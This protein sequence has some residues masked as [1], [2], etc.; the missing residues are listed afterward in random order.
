MAGIVLIKGSEDADSGKYQKHV[1]TGKTRTEQT[2]RLPSAS[3]GERL[4][5]D[6]THWHLILNFYLL[7][8]RGN[9]FLLFKPH[10][11]WSN[12]EGQLL[13]SFLPHF[14]TEILVLY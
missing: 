11:L 5:G 10:S 9:K 7:E 3:Q 1:H 2:V 8:L 4:R 6:R 12:P 14:I 13:N